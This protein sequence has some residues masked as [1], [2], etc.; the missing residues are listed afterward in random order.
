MR[1]WEV[2][3]LTTEID[4]F[5]C[6]TLSKLNKL[7]SN[8]CHFCGF[9]DFFFF[10]IHRMKGFDVFC[11]E[12]F[13]GTLFGINWWFRRNSFRNAK[14]SQLISGRD[15]WW[16]PKWFNFVRLS[17]VSHYCFYQCFCFPLCIIFW[18]NMTDV[19][20]KAEIVFTW[21]SRACAKIP[22][23]DRA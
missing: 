3:L 4:F 2:D 21:S 16:E 5:A 18:L 10:C 9:A 15:L 12:T 8:I 11:R 14:L 22:R 1:G 6:I 17:F 19:T 20:R 23:R 13:R 7:A